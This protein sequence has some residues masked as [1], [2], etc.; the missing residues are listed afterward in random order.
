MRDNEHIPGQKL[1]VKTSPIKQHLND[2]AAK[3][4]NYIAYGEFDPAVGNHDF[5]GRL[6]Q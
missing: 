1:T 5:A 6:I 3:Y 4:P 2:R